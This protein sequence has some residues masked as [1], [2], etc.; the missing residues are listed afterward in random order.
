MINRKNHNFGHL[1]SKLADNKKKLVRSST[2]QLF[3]KLIDIF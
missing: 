1:E 2:Y 3:I